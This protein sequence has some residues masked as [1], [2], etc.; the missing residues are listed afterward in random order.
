M[1]SSFP[2]LVPEEVQ[3]DPSVELSVEV[4]EPEEEDVPV[5]VPVESA[6]AVI[7]EKSDSED[8]NSAVA[9]TSD[10]NT[11]SGCKEESPSTEE[12]PENQDNEI[13]SKAEEPLEESL[14]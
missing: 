5:G 7:T 13:E 9:T 1:S 2:A 6:E 4:H 8:S 3:I 14:E 11:D 10:E 12:S